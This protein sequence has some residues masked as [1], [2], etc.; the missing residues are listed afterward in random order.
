MHLLWRWSDWKILEATVY[1]LGNRNKVTQILAA[2]WGCVRLRSVLDNFINGRTIIASWTPVIPSVMNSLIDK[3]TKVKKY[4]PSFTYETTGMAHHFVKTCPSW[5][6]NLCW[7]CFP[8][9]HPPSFG[10]LCTQWNTVVSPHN[11]G[12][13]DC[14][15][16]S[17]EDVSRSNGSNHLQSWT[18]LNCEHLNIFQQWWFAIIWLLQKWTL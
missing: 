6:A 5:P 15:N 18:C 11:A 8:K 16:G 4:I 7:P 13:A 2:P 12:T 3:A 9:H 17:L 14:S 1:C 10:L